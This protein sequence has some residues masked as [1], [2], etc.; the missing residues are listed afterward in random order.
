LAYVI[1]VFIYFCSKSQEDTFI[2]YFVR[3]FSVFDSYNPVRKRTAPA[4]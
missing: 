2:V 1:K 4:L 3:I